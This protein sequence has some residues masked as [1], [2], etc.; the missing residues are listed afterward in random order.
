MDTKESPYGKRLRVAAGKE[1]KTFWSAYRWFGTVVAFLT[2]FG[3]QLHNHG[4]QSMLNMADVAESGL[5]GLAISLAGNY[6]TA[7]YKGAK[8]I[9]TG[10]RNE[11]AASEHTIAQLTE[12]RLVKFDFHLEEDPATDATVNMKDG[13]LS[14]SNYRVKNVALCVANKGQAPIGIVR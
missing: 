10:Q 2:P 13:N 3:V 9:D 7:L 12:H 4:P 6:I 1:F 14:S 5:L 11:L 8:A